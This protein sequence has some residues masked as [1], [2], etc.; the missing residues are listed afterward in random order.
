MLLILYICSYKILQKL[1]AVYA[2][3]CHIFMY[4]Y[5]HIHLYTQVNGSV[6]SITVTGL[7]S[8]TVYSCTIFGYSQIVGP[9][10][11]P[12]LITTSQAGKKLSLLF[13]GKFLCI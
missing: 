11:D 7:L 12:L 13:T 4:L 2:L 1:Y 8:F 6:N 10:S 5:I 3:M 9:M